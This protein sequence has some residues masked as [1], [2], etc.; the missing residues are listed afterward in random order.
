MQIA[1][2]VW[3]KDPSNPLSYRPAPRNKDENLPVGYAAASAGYIGRMYLRGEGVKANAAIAKMWFER[4]VEYGDRECHNGLGI[5]YR[6]GLIKGLKP[7]VV[8]AAN[9]FGKAAGQELAEAQVN[10]AK[11]HYGE[12]LL[13]GPQYHISL[14]ASRT[15]RHWKSHHLL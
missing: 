2:Q 5:I 10:L 13:C 14:I 15:R 3:P 8:K 11:I 12:L 7:D 1:R 6:D 4:G 9:H